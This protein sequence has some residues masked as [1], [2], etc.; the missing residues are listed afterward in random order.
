MFVEKRIAE[1]GIEL[2]DF[3]PARALYVPV[4]VSGRTVYV[5]GQVPFKNNE[6]LYKGKVGAERTLEEAQAAAKQCIYN[7]LA[8]LKHAVG[9]LDKIACC[10]KLTAF[11]SSAP[12]FNQQHIVVN[13]GSQILIDVFGDRGAHA[14]SAVGLSELPMGA[15]VEI[16]GIF[17]LKE[18]LQN[19]LN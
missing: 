13:A 7:M 16:E 14:R 19:R 1:L 17:E 18:E 6:L 15:T 3:A 5:S 11:V 9:D 8:A 2:P 12:G 4:R 10:L